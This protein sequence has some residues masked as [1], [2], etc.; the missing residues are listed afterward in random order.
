MQALFEQGWRVKLPTEAQWEKAARGADGRIYPWGN[1]FDANKAN[2]F[3]TGIGS[4]S[5]VGCF[6]GGKSPYGIQDMSGNVLEWCLDW[7]DAEYYAKSPKQ[8]PRGPDTGQYKWLRGGS[9]G[10]IQ[11][12]TRCASR[13]RIDPG[14]TSY[15][16]GFRCVLSR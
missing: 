8:D 2:T 5:P 16:V 3:E 12:F 13:V 4:T 7:Y 6:E 10:V 1:D 14:G 11:L 15:I 9:W